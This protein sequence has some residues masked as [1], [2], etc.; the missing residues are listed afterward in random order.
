M[1]LITGATGLVGS[2][3]VK[4]LAKTNYNIIALYNKNK[5]NSE[6]EKLATWKQVD[7]LDVVALEEVIKGVK[8]VYH[9]AAMVSFNA[10]DKQE[11]HHLNI[12]GTKNVV[13]ACILLGTE[14]LVHVSSVATLDRYKKD[15][16]VNEKTYSNLTSK[17]SEYAKSKIASENEVWRA[18]GEGLN[19]VIVN[20]SIILGAGNWQI[21]STAIFKNCYNEFKWYTNGSNGFVDAVDVAKAMI[22]LMNTPIANERFIVNGYNL[23]YKQVFDT[24]ANKFNKKKPTKLASPFLGAI[25]WRVE[26]IKSFFTNA[27]PLITKETAATAQ[28]LIKYDNSKLLHFLPEYTYSNFEESIDRICKELKQKY[29]L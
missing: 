20:P 3:I 24:I 21:G 19:A 23:T 2:H 1:I 29:H 10:I 14:K 9:C 28:Q 16:L 26:K 27:K 13:N 5:P 15:E 18:M 12:E 7:I 22:A 6:I 8:Q 17:N 11:M 4:E 25:A